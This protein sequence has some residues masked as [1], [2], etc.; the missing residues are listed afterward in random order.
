MEQLRRTT[1]VWFVVVLEVTWSQCS[2]WCS[3]PCLQG[4]FIG[5]LASSHDLTT[6]ICWQANWWLWPDLRREWVLIPTPSP[7]GSLWQLGL[8]LAPA[9]PRIKW[10]IV[11]G[12]QIQMLNFHFY[13]AR[14]WHRELWRR[15]A[16]AVNKPE[17]I[18]RNSRTWTKGWRWEKPGKDREEEWARSEG[19]WLIS[20]STESADSVEVSVA[21]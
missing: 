15:A 5:T 7:A 4:F 10:E 6:C 2:S 19:W 17:N 9:K 3:P 1:N 21:C 14:K 13:T 12:I 20:C 16:E 18:I 11:D 8:L